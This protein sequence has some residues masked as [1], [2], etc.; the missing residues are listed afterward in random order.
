VRAYGWLPGLLLAAAVLAAGCSD[1]PALNTGPLGN[2]GGAGQQCVPGRVGQPVTLGL[3]AFRNMGRSPAVITRVALAD[4]HGLRMT[5]P[6]IVAIT[7]TAEIGIWDTF[8]P[9]LTPDLKGP[10]AHRRPAVGARLTPGRTFWNL[11]FA[12]QP[13]TSRYG[14]SNGVDLWYTEGG[15]QYRLRTGVTL[16]VT[17]RHKS[18]F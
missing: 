4:P 5:S 1:S 6:V 7:S 12:L 8:P 11:V 10:W 16:E 15:Q 17:T 18:C 14:R 13:T 3:Y 2:G 9:Q